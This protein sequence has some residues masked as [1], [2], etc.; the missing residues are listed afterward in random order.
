[1]LPGQ[2][3]TQRS[4]L[5]HMV[6]LHCIIVLYTLFLYTYTLAQIGFQFVIY[7]HA[8]KLM[9]HTNSIKVIT[10]TVTKQV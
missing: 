7:K 6:Y 3:H 1:M 8:F 9:I 4:M 2:H 10:K 5:Q